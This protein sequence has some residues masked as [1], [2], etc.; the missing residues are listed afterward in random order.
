MIKPSRLVTDGA[1][2]DFSCPMPDPLVIT[3]QLAKDGI[4]TYLV[5]FSATGDIKP[6]GT[7]APFL[8][9]MACAGLTAQG[10]PDTCVMTAEGYKAKDPMGPT[11]YLQAS[12]GAALSTTFDGIA[13]QICCNCVN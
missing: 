1:D 13:A 4:K 5:G 12:D 11:L 10:F 9:D 7:G 8:N 2:W 6:G 3:Q